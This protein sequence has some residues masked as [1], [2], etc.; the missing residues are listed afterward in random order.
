[1]LF[2]P[3]S[4]E[5]RSARRMGGA[6]I[7]AV[8]FAVLIVMLWQ[9]YRQLDDRAGNL[10][11]SGICGAGDAVTGPQDEQLAAFAHRA[12]LDFPDVFVTV[13]N[14]VNATGD[15]PRGYLT[16]SEARQTGWRPGRNRW[17]TAP[18]K[19]IG[20]DRFGNREKRLPATYNGR[21]READLDFNGHRDGGRRGAHRLVFVEG[22]RGQWLMWVTI[23]HYDS[24]RQIPRP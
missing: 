6:F 22:S 18:S 24:F 9:D 3:D 13:A 1:M 11:Q 2:S 20:G 23:D 21:Y 7:L 19:A 8:S 5:K 16:K 4:P 15:L 14:T 10:A 17:E 12:G